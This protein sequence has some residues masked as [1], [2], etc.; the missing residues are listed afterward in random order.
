MRCWAE[1]DP[2]SL[3][4][5]QLLRIL[6]TARVKAQCYVLSTT[7]INPLEES[8]HCKGLNGSRRPLSS[9]DMSEFV[10]YCFAIT[11]SE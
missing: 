11:A 3:P 2:G 6:G 8:E 4:E 5:W 7:V 1:L 10:T 9:I